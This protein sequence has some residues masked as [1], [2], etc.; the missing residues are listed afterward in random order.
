MDYIKPVQNALEFIEKN[1]M[2]EIR[3]KDVAREAAISKFHFHRI[4]LAVAGNSVAGYIRRRRLTEAA[5]ELMQTHKKIIDMA[6]DYQFGAPESF[7]RAFKN[8]YGVT[9]GHYRSGKDHFAARHQAAIQ[10]DIL[11]NLKGGTI[12]EPKIITK[13]TFKVIGMTYYGDNQKN[14]IQRLWENFLPEEESI[15]NRI[16][17]DIGYGICYPVEDP[18][19]T[20]AFEYLAAVEVSNLDEIP[21]GMEGRTI[22]A[23][24]YAVFLHRGPVDKITETYQT[25]YALWQPKSGYELIKAPDFECY[26]ER[27]RPD[28]PEI[29]ELDIYIPIQG[30]S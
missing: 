30:K 8:M 19:N 2:Q 3:S 22:P 29:S 6:L 21:E 23:Q 18:D 20:S 12:V 25:I 13:E 17:P 1:L 14:E 15:K 11:S 7:S 16:H 4:F 28:Q 5:Y 10:W 26:D 24:K 9:P 27:F